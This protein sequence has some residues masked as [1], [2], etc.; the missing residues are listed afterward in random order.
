MIDLTTILDGYKE[1][2]AGR[3][4]ARCPGPNHENGDRIPS[5]SIRLVDGDRWLLHCFSGGC[6]ALDIVHALGLELSDLFEGEHKPQVPRRS[7]VPASDA[8][9]A[10]DHECMVVGLIAADVVEHKAIDE[11]TWKRLALAVSKISA[12]RAACCPARIS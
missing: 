1:T 4:V 8:L 11:G 10:L 5:L 6:E 12:A 7:R 2:G 3:G 9:A